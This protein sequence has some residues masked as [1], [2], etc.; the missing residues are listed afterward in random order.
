MDHG[1][2]EVGIL[3]KVF[4]CNTFVDGRTGFSEAGLCIYDDPLTAL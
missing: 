3:A 4:T 1:D 2:M